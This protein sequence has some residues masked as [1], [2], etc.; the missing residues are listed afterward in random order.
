MANYV[1]TGNN[2]LVRTSGSALSR[3]NVRRM[4]SIMQRSIENVLED[5]GPFLGGR[6]VVRESVKATAYSILINMHANSLIS[7]YNVD[8]E[9]G[10]DNKINCTIKFKPAKSIH[11]AIINVAVN[12][13]LDGYFYIKQAGGKWIICT[14][15]DI[16]D[17]N[18]V[19]MVAK[20]KESIDDWEIFTQEA[21]MRDAALDDIMVWVE[22][23]ELQEKT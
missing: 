15:R 13:T 2:A 23:L 10:D 22:N 12:K 8:V 21:V 9:N 5:P 3:I 7:C 18:Y 11:Y 20:I 1:R 4:I 14:E 19:P 6:K 17:P 16:Y